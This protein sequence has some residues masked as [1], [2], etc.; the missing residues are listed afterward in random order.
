[1]VFSY[2]NLSSLEYLRNWD[3]LEEL[4]IIFSELFTNVYSRTPNHDLTPQNV[5]QSSSDQ[6]SAEDKSK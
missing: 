3:Q 5:L 4:N 1:M 6:F 2:T